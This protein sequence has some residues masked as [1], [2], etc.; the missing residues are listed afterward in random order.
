MVHAVARRA[1][2]LA[3]SLT[4]PHTF[5][6]GA[7][8]AAMGPD[9]IDLTMMGAVTVPRSMLPSAAHARELVVLAG[10]VTRQ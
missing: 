10:P 1:D 8:Y 3:S 7:V 4:Q 6:R 9:Y 5:G 2:G